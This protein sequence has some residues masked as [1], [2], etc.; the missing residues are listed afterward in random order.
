MKLKKRIT[1]HT[2]THTAVIIGILLVSNSFNHGNILQFG[3]VSVHGTRV[4]LAAVL[5]YGPMNRYTRRSGIFSRASLKRFVKFAMQTAIVS[6][7]I[8]PSS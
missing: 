2:E 6:S 7:T 4:T 8:S 3:T 5:P 1:I